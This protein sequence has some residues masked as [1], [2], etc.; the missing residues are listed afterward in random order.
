MEWGEQ[1]S[2]LREI[3][4]AGTI[5]KALLLKPDL[6]E[7]L[8]DVWHAFWALSGDRSY[9]GLGGVGPI[10]FVAIDRYA[11]RFGVA[12]GDDFVRFHALLKRMDATFLEHMAEKAKQTQEPHA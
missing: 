11:E 7:H 1:E 12:P 10:P 4:E 2:W 9:G 8:D 5:P 6:P 3:A